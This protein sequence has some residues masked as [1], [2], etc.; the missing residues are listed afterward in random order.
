MPAAAAEA[1]RANA[2]KREV[3]R[4]AVPTVVDGYAVPGASER[5]FMDMVVQPMSPKELRNLPPGQNTLDWRN[6]WS[7][8]EVKLRD[9]VKLRDGNFVVQSVVFWEDGDFWKATA[10]RVLDQL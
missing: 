2:R 8:C 10:S 1:I 7:L 5:L 9:V 4:P 3:A 6:I